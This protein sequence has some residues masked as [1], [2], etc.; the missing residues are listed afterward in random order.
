MNNFIDSKTKELSDEP[1]ILFVL[2]LLL[3]TFDMNSIGVII[4]T[5]ILIMTIM[6]KL[7]VNNKFFFLIYSKSK[8]PRDSGGFGSILTLFW[9]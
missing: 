9:S 1:E 4:A 6:F 3:I 7:Y 8:S 5:L 2:M